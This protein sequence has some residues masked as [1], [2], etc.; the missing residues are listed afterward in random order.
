[1]AVKMYDL[2]DYIQNEKVFFK[3]KITRQL[4]NKHTA[5]YAKRLPAVSAKCFEFDISTPRFCSSIISSGYTTRGNA[6]FP[7][8]NSRRDL[9]G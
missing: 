7:V 8:Q 9:F 6:C 3:Y 5:V 2:R 4:K 1:M